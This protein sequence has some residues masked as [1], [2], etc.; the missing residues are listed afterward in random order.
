MNLIGED[1]DRFD[2]E[3]SLLWQ[4]CMKCRVVERTHYEFNVDYLLI[5]AHF[6]TEQSRVGELGGEML[7]NHVGI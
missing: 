6:K 5:A 1:V 3:L 4:I 7:E 2:L